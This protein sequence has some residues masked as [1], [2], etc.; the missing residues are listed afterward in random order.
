M[1]KGILWA[2]DIP[3]FKVNRALAEHKIKSSFS[4]NST[5]GH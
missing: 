3:P 5:V 2:A 1:V 4:Q